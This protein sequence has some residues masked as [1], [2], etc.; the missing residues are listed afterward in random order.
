MESSDNIVQTEIL[1][2]I[3]DFEG[4]YDDEEVDILR[5]LRNWIEQTECRK[6]LS[7][8][9]AAL[10]DDRAL[11]CVGVCRPSLRLVCLKQLASLNT[12]ARHHDRRCISPPGRKTSSQMSA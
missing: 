6:A 2:L 4:E 7:A 8:L 12:Q 5:E 9:C 1:I 11:P 3:L 10:Q